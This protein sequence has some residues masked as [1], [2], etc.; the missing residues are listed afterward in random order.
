[1]DAHHAAIFRAGGAADETGGFGAF[2]QP[3]NIGC[4]GDEAA[5]DVALRDT[6]GAGS[7]DDAQ[8]VV[9]RGGETELAEVLLHA[10]PKHGGRAGDVE[11]DFLL[12]R[13]EWFALAD[14]F[15]E[16]RR[17]RWCPVYGCSRGWIGAD[18]GRNPGERISM[19][20]KR[21]CGVWATRCWR[22]A[23]YFV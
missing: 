23:S 7:G 3:G 14:F 17:H 20:L 9:L 5:C 4:F 11:Q 15:L 6:C 8:Y 13:V 18:D 2:E 22:I 10:M 1:M 21:V 16:G 19:A 12:E